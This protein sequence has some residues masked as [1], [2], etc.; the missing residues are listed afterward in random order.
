MTVHYARVSPEGTVLRVI[1]L[2]DDDAPTEAAGQAFIAGVLKL[3]GTW[4]RTWP[5]GSARK[6]YAG[7]G[8]TYDPVGDVFVAP[9]PFPSWTVDEA[10]DWQPP[11]PMPGEGGPWV[12]DEDT[13][14]WVTV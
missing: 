10:H 11:V 3:A 9:Q 12:W 2:A 7:P 6:Q 14:E 8:F 13:L 4:V 1:C 5:D